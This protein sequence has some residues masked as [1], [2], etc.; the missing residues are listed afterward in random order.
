M[1]YLINNVNFI[2]I[3]LFV[4]KSEIFFGLRADSISHKISTNI[5]DV[6]SDFTR[7][8]NSYSGCI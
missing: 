7:S 3:L 1:F 8:R 2:C 4:A 6:V 5:N